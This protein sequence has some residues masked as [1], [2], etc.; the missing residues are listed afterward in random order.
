M[1]STDTVS[2]P[3]AILGLLGLLAGIY[4]FKK[5]NRPDGELDKNI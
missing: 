1:E 2:Y 4:Y 5:I 3:L